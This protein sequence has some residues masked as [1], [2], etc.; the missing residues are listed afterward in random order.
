MDNKSNNAEINNEGLAAGSTN[1]SE[2]GV[3]K[4]TADSIPQE[5]FIVSLL[6]PSGVKVCM[7][8][9]VTDNKLLPIHFLLFYVM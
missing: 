9:I 7:H 8:T 6:T 4:I 2:A 1:S 3:W 5:Y